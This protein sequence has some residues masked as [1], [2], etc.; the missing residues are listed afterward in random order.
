MNRI[1]LNEREREKREVL[2]GRN[3]DVT[4]RPSFERRRA[5]T[6]KEDCAEKG[7][8]SWDGNIFPEG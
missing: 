5:L 1:S 3:T 4:R 2:H 7:E 6:S 8:E